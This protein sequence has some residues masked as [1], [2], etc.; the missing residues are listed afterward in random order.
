MVAS[1]A[2]ADVVYLDGHHF[3]QWCHASVALHA[4][5]VHSNYRG[6][7][8]GFN[9]QLCEG[10]TVGLAEAPPFACTGLGA[11]DHG[12]CGRPV[13]V[14]P[15]GPIEPIGSTPSYSGA[16]KMARDVL[17]WTVKLLNNV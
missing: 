12:G 16:E 11:R 7:T 8:A 15:P 3:S 4:R 13:S 6:K 5:N 2:D 1:A 9:T 17:E 10:R 14:A